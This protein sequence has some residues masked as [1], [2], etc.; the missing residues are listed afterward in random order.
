MPAVLNEA[1]NSPF[2]RFK[3]LNPHGQLESTGTESIHN[4][5]WGGE[6]QFQAQNQVQHQAQNQ[7][8]TQPQQ[9]HYQLLPSQ[10][11]EWA[12]PQYQIQTQQQHIEPAKLNMDHDCDRLIAIIMSC[13]HCRNRLRSIMSTD[14]N[15]APAPA[16]SQR[17]GGD[18]VP[19]LPNLNNLSTTTI[20][21]FIFGIAVIFLVDRII[22]LAKQ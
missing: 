7:Q 6:Q 10:T 1:F 13:P 15:P 16:P 19:S 3:G 11:Q 18:L 21:N 8:Q 9:F 14:S 4:P 12:Q 2:H 17:G 20:G 5:L 22:R